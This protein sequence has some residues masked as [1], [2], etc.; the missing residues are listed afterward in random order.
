[1]KTSEIAA[2]PVNQIIGGHAHLYLWITN[3]FLARGAH[4]QVAEAW[5]FR[6]VTVLTWRKLGRIGLG[7]YFR[8]TTEH[9]VFCVRGAPPYKI[10][11]DGKRAQGVTDF[12]DNSPSSGLSG[13]EMLLIEKGAWWEESR[14]GAH[15]KKPPKIHEWAEL[16]SPGPYLEMFART[17]RVGWDAWGNEAP[18]ALSLEDV[19]NG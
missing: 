13:A 19:I 18:E 17:A 9:V 1:M 15:S 12:D 2:L 5:G 4:V 3:N 11:E 7:Q 8:G 6:P 10:K 14:P 16:V